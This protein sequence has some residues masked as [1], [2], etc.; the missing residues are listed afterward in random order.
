MTPET[1]KKFLTWC[2]KRS[3]FTE[4]A[5]AKVLTKMGIDD[6]VDELVKLRRQGLLDLDEAEDSA[7]EYKI[8][9]LGREEIK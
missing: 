1:Q 8:T 3:W 4:T 2:S 6:P 5:G 7:W 9:R